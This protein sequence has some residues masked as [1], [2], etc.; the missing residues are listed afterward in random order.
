M[1]RRFWLGLWLLGWP[2]AAPATDVALAE[3]MA[4]LAA[5]RTVEASFREEKN[6]AILDEPLVATGRLYYRAPSYLRKQTLSPRPEEYVA[7]QNWLTVETPDG[8]RRQFDLNGYPQLRPFVEAIRATQA[9]DRPTLERYY[10]LEFEGTP[11]AWSLRLTPRQ[12]EFARYLI[13]IVIRGRE[14]WIDSVE[15]LE[16]GGDRGLLTVEPR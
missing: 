8:E 9:G 14:Q 11:T 16:S 4:A 10:Q 3:V 13:A 5:V 1:N 12:P 2:L 7:D 6:L 15:T